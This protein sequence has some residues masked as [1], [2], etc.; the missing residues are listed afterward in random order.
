AHDRFGVAVL[1]DLVEVENAFKVRRFCGFQLAAQEDVLFPGGALLIGVAAV[2][3]GD[4]WSDL[5]DGDFHFTRPVLAAVP[6][7]RFPDLGWVNFFGVPFLFL[8][9][10]ILRVILFASNF[11]R[12]YIRLFSAAPSQEEGH[13]YSDG[14]N[15]V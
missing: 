1:G 8:L 10:L 12:F 6:G 11:R 5:G 15:A 13:D 14:K 7:V 2:W 3:A 4:H 9:F